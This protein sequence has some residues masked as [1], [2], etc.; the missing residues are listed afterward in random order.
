MVQ[1]FDKYQRL[2]N[3]EEIEYV[4]SFLSA[5]PPRSLQEF[6]DLL[7]KYDDL[8]KSI[9]VE[10]YRTDFIGPFEI[11]KEDLIKML[12]QAAF[13]CKELLLNRVISDCQQHSKR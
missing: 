4:E 5:E 6:G 7:R 11:N 8:Y 13:Y 10:F 3:R 9:L 1:E 2:M 12:S